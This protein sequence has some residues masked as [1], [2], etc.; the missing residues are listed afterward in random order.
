[1]NEMANE[2]KMF[3]KQRQYS[4]NIEMCNKMYTL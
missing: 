2:T 3:T 4:N 1:M